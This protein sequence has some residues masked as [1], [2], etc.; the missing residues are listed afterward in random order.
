M[1]RYDYLIVGAGLFGAVC[2]YRLRKAGKSFLMIDKKDHIGGLSYV[3]Y[4]KDGK[5]NDFNDDKKTLEKNEVA[6]LVHKYGA[7]IFHTDNEKIWEFINSFIDMKPFINTPIA[8]YREKYYNL[9]FNMNTFNQLYGTGDYQKVKE[10]ITKETSYYKKIYPNPSNLE[11]QALSLVGMTA[12]VTL[13]KEFTEKLWGR[14]CT[15]LPGSIIKRIPIRYEYNNNYYDDRFQGVGN[16]YE[17]ITKLIDKKEGERDIVLGEDYHKDREK[18]N[19]LADKVIYSGSLDEL[20][21]YQYGSLDYR[22]IKFETEIQDVKNYQATPIMHFIDRDVP[23]NRITEHKH[24][25]DNNYFKGFPRYVSANTKSVISK[26][27][28]QTYKLGEEP[29][30]PINDDKNSDLYKVLKQKA[31]EIP[32]FYFGGRLAEYKYYDMDDVIESALQID[33][34]EDVPT[35]NFF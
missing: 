28:T 19:S 12:Y 30:Y 11:E 32:N 26:E 2:A 27:I 20:F 22:S 8:K 17:L 25:S 35:I 14:P 18:W 29:H 21:D 1:K 31:R 5:I 23:Y 7:H 9:P 6:Y 33:L 4:Y 34:G 3:Q 13:I 15:E 10:I 16:Y 24:L